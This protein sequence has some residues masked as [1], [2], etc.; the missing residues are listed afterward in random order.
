MVWLD[1]RLDVRTGR[2]CL[3]IDIKQRRPLTIWSLLEVVLTTEGL[4][5]TVRTTVK[6]ILAPFAVAALLWQVL[7]PAS[8]R[9]VLALFVLFILIRDILAP[10]AALVL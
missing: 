1:A 9:L 4:T 3:G 7:T 5:G 10:L 2:P 6:I 8:L